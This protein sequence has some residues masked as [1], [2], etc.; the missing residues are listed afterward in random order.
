M[1]S[2]FRSFDRTV[3]T[4]ARKAP[5]TKIP[6]ACTKRALTGRAVRLELDVEARD[7]Y[8]RLLAYIYLDGGR[9]PSGC[10]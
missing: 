4:P 10:W 5:L 1:S 3:L 6:A 9:T 2:S 8:R 7:K